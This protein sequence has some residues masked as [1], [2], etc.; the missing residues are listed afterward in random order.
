MLNPFGKVPTLATNDGA[1]LYP[2]QVIVEYLDSISKANKLYPAGGPERFDAL[3]H[4]GIGDSIFEFAVQMSMEGWRDESARRPDL[5]AWLWPKITRS[6]DFL[7]RECDRWRG[8]DIGDVGLLQG[9]SYLD[10]MVAKSD[11][12]PENPCRDW[13]GNWPKLAAWF[14]QSLQRASVQNDYQIPYE[15]DSS[16]QFY[17]RKVEQALTLMKV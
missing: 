16:P 8:F 2:S 11:N 3:R 6:F 14:Q 7:E 10:A 4:L 12:S 13:Q 9:I 1:I 17:R 15:G 5:Y